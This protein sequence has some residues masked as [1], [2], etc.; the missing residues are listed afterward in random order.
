MFGLGFLGARGPGPLDGDPLRRAAG[1]IPILVGPPNFSWTALQR[2]A[3]GGVVGNEDY[4]GRRGEDISCRRDRSHAQAR[5]EPGPVPA[6]MG[7]T[8]SRATG[9][10]RPAR[11]QHVRAGTS[12]RGGPGLR[13][14]GALPRP[15]PAVRG[16]AGPPLR[17]GSPRG[18]GLG[19]ARSPPVTVPRPSGCW[20]PWPLAAAVRAAGALSAPRDGQARPGTAMRAVCRRC[21]LRPGSDV[22]PGEQNWPGAALRAWGG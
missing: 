10:R 7:P 5:L 18:R 19:M 3:R 2:D 13:A 6:A 11:G 8:R 20:P 9:P 17:P 16:G 12:A 14:A 22:F 15:G 1:R 4:F 21:A